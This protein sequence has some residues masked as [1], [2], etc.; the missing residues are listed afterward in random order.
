MV[1]NVS[2]IKELVADRVE[3]GHVHIGVSERQVHL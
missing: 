3:L 2:I 1:V